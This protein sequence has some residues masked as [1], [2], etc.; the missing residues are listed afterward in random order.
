M[1]V[2]DVHIFRKAFSPSFVPNSKPQD[3][4]RERN[5]EPCDRWTDSSNSGPRMHISRLD[6]PDRD[7]QGPSVSS[8]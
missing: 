3:I 7:N 5:L 1:K 4:V 2:Q 6:T 8:V